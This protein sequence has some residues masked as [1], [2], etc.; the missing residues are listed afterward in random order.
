MNGRQILLAVMLAIAVLATG[1][2]LLHERE[3]NAPPSFSG[4]P[5]SDYQL[6]NFQLA[7]Y[8]ENG[9]LSFQLESPRLTHD[10]ARSAFHVDAPVFKFY[11]SDGKAW[12]ATSKR[13]QIGTIDKK[14]AMRDD[15]R[16]AQA[17]GGAQGKFVLTT[18]S[19]DADTISKQL[20]SDVT[21]TVQRP[22]SILRGVGLIAN[23][24]TRQFDLAAAVRGRFEVQHD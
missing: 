14:V 5:R 12:N 9:R 6:E 21:V 3:R 11:N 18:Q 24:D 7:S 10:D 4:P 1:W 22:G 23:L 16:V 19:L 20:T 8:D 13:A 17:A 15:V 2:L